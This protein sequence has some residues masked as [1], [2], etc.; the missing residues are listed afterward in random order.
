MVWYKN[1]CLLNPKEASSLRN[2]CGCVVK[3]PYTIT[4]FAIGVAAQLER[5]PYIVSLRR[6]GT[7][8]H[9]CGGTL[10]ARRVV[11][12][13]AHCIDVRRFLDA[14]ERPTVYI[15]GYQR[16]AERSNRF[17]V[18]TE[19]DV[20]VGG[21]V[22]SMLILCIWVNTLY[23]YWLIEFGHGTDSAKEC[24]FAVNECSSIGDSG[25]LG[26]EAIGGGLETVSQTIKMD[27]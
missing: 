6:R 4:K 15:G 25:H 1:Q 24:M 17:D 19:T 5:Y 16:D 3:G 26:W 12:T 18:P 20:E 10:I 2:P 23:D 8:A 22:C 14:E 13:A 21:S 27:K 9:Y 11:L 7:R